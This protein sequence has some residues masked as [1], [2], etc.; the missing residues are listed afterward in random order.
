VAIGWLFEDEATDEGDALLDRVA[1][2]GAVVPALWHYEV[3][4]VLLQATRRGRTAGWRV[5]PMLQYLS[6]LP[7]RTEPEPRG[8]DWAGI[9]VSADALGLTAYDA[10]Y[11]DLAARLNLPLATRDG[12][13]RKA[14]QKLGRPVLPA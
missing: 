2:E 14:M 11:V 3:A 7:I 1:R 4:D 9:I 10:A 13:V 5:L 8:T 6:R 12:G